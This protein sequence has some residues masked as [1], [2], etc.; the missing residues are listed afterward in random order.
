[1]NNVLLPVAQPATTANQAVARKKSSTD[2]TEGSEFAS[3]LANQSPASSNKV[4]ADTDTQKPG[5]AKST[6]PRAHA[7]AGQAKPNQAQTAPN[8]SDNARLSYSSLA[9]TRLVSAELQQV[10]ETL[11]ASRSGHGRAPLEPS[12]TDQ[13]H[14]SS[15]LRTLSQAIGQS[16]LSIRASAGQSSNSAATPAITL[17]NVHDSRFSTFAARAHHQ[18][19][20]APAAVQRLRLLNPALHQGKGATTHAQLA[21]RRETSQIADSTA[22]MSTAK[23]SPSLAASLPATKTSFSDTNERNLTALQGTG[24]KSASAGTERALPQGSPGHSLHG[25]LAAPA[26]ELA[27][28]AFAKTLTMERPLANPQWGTELGQQVSNLVRHAGAGNHSAELRLDP[29][30]LGPLRITLNLHDSVVQAVFSSAHASVRHAVEQALPQ[31]QQQLEQEGLSLGQ[32]N[33]GEHHQGTGPFGHHHDQAQT[34][35]THA[36]SANSPSTH[37]DEPAH[38]LAVNEAASGHRPAADALIDTFV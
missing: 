5:Q 14:P 38:H 18:D 32:T 25:H 31:L 30:H 3:I 6:G 11:S 36:A 16:G 8:T 20:H 22:R 7:T 13:A 26:S 27:P 37:H 29:P 28:E 17:A 12:G 21:K 10:L 2:H 33:V 1:M 35:N 4:P 23:N 19:T 9:E 34:S 24:P 15:R